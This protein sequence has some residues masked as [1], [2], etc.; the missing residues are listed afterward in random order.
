MRVKKAYV[1]AGVLAAVFLLG[2]VFAPPVLSAYYDKD[3]IGIVE[4]RMLPEGNAAYRYQLSNRERAYI[5]S[6]AR[7]NL[8]ASQRYNSQSLITEALRVEAAGSY[9][10]NESSPYVLL[11]NER[12]SGSDEY[13]EDEIR[14]VCE[15]E[16]VKLKSLLELPDFSYDVNASGAVLFSVVN[17]S[18]PAM[19]IAVW[20]LSSDKSGGW[21]F[22]VDAQTGRI[23]DFSVALKEETDWES[24]D[25]EAIA[26]S[27]C[28]YLEL[29]E[30]EPYKRDDMLERTPY[31]SKFLVRLLEDEMIITIGLN[32]ENNNFFIRIP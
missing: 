20:E 14:K 25:T 27:F 15:A 4:T 5:F 9:S 17:A 31:Y 16:A 7:E 24:F 13:T 2:C 26:A 18:D 8:S 1:R 28:K 21:Q 12:G 3:I 32:P 29:P 19:N 30:P 22:E 10:G 23:Y 6:R 11:I